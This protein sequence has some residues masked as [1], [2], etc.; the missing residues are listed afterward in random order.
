MALN[1]L[2]ILFTNS[3]THSIDAACCSVEILLIMNSG[4]RNYLPRGFN[5]VWGMILAMTFNMKLAINI[6]K[7]IKINM[8]GT[9]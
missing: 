9:E 8:G 6:S 7:C 4:H 1:S 2:S 3:N 5:D